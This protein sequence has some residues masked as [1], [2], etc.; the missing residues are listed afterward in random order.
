M[1]ICRNLVVFCLV[2]Q[3]IGLGLIGKSS[4]IGAAYQLCSY[5]VI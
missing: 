3:V 2:P 5:G 4:D 1:Q